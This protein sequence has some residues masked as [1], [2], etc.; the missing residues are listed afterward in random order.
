MDS[1]WSASMIGFVVLYFIFMSA[2]IVCFAIL[3]WKSR[4][5]RSEIVEWRQ[6]TWLTGLVVS[7]FSSLAAPALMLGIQFLSE[8]AKSAWFINAAGAV[9]FVSFVGSPIAV[10]LLG[11]GKG[12]LRWVGIASEAMVLLTSFVCLV[13]MS[14]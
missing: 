5:W 14:G 12:K 10:T 8:K 11:F 9:V 2:P 4:A 1:R 6:R 3:F 13:G 7:F